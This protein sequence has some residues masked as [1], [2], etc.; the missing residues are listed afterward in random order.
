MAA[1]S[2]K[3]YKLVP[4]EVPRRQRTSYYTEIIDDFQ[5]SGQQSAAVEETGKKAVTLVQGLRKALQAEGLTDIS[6]VQRGDKTFLVRG[7]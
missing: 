3:G 1:A 5:R 6:V 4:S 7:S 2:G